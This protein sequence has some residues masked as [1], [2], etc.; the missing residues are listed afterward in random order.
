M[1][2]NKKG[3]VLLAITLDMEGPSDCGY[4]GDYKGNK[5][6]FP[7]YGK[8][9]TW[10]EID[11]DFREIIDGDFREK[12]LDSFG[13]PMR[14][15]FFWLD[16]VGFSEN[17][18]EQVIGY[19]AIC[20]HFGK[21]PFF[22]ES[23]RKYGDGKSMHF[24]NPRPDGSWS[25]NDKY[26][27]EQWNGIDFQEDVF[28]S[29]LAHN[30]VDRHWF[31]RTCRM[32]GT[33]ENE[34]ISQFLERYIPLDFSCR[35]E[36][37]FKEK[38]GKVLYDWRE[39]EDNLSFYHPAEGDYKKEGSMQ[40]FIFPYLD[41]GKTRSKPLFTAEKIEE[42]FERARKG[43]NMVFVPGLHDFDP[44]KREDIEQ[45]YK[46]M[47]K[48]SSKYG[49][50]WSY[51]TCL[52]AAKKILNKTDL[53]CTEISSSKFAKTPSINFTKNRLNMKFNN[54]KLFGEPFVVIRRVDSYI[55]QIVEGKYI[56]PR[57]YE[58]EI[59]KL[60]KKCMVHISLTDKNLEHKNYSIDL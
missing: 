34:E 29:I 57:E 55:Y 47:I 40:R 25:A 59:P 26:P 49:I 5:K 14:F 27:F 37:S 17:P 48:N 45:A 28:K 19:H 32:G 16:W 51:E 12:H 58:V 2:D 11:K 3:K 1:A 60:N 53:P 33:L 4:L 46:L 8:Y 18:R 38:E 24:H 44:E 35:G 6:D 10:E 43:E 21:N 31:P 56:S 52:S 22:F 23:F 30:L 41:F 36:N 15:D 54:S 42:G 39:R 20:D 7:N 13:N 50:K 9:K